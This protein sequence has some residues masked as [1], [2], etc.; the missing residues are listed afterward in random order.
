MLNNEQKYT[1]CPEGVGV[2]DG[3]L[4]R[5]DLGQDW[6]CETSDLSSAVA[7]HPIEIASKFACGVSIHCLDVENL[8]QARYDLLL[9]G[10]LGLEANGALAQEVTHVDRGAQVVPIGGRAESLGRLWGGTHGGE[11]QAQTTLG[12]VR[13]IQKLEGQEVIEIAGA[14]SEAAPSGYG[15]PKLWEAIEAH[16]GRFQSISQAVH[17]C[18]APARIG[19]EYGHVAEAE[20]IISDWKTS[21]SI[22]QIISA[23]SHVKPRA[24]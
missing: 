8:G 12:C 6:S 22:G 20:L 11:D 18:K 16:H 17:G 9:G 3:R 1:E 5:L 7:K 2:Q 24:R 4:V 13:L 19:Q 14:E 10:G 23:N 21:V 15:H